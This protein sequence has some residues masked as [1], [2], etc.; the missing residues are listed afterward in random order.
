MKIY[1]NEGVLGY[2]R[3]LVP[4]LLRIYPYAALQFAVYDKLKLI[5]IPNKDLEVS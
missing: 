4:S 3:G 1:N 5:L 2:W